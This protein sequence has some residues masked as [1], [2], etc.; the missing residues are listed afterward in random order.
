MTGAL[1]LSTDERP[2]SFSDADDPKLA[3]RRLKLFEGL[4]EGEVSRIAALGRVVKVPQDRVL[5]R[6]EAGKG[7]YCFL[8]RGQVAFAEFEAGKVPEPPKNKKKRITPVMQVCE[9]VVA[10]FDVGDVFKNDHVASARGEDGVKRDMALFSCIHVIMLELPQA[11]LDKVLKDLP[12]VRDRVDAQAEA[13]FYKQTLLKVDGRSE[14]L[15]FYVKQGF[16]YADAIKVI[17][18]DKCI[19]CDECVMACEDRHGIARIE[20]FGPRVG[21]MQFTLNCRSCEDARCIDVCNFDA[22]G[23]DDRVP[24]PE[25]VVYDNCVGCTKCAKACPHE[26]IRM[27][28]IQEP[29][30]VDLVGMVEA[31]R[32]RPVTRVAKG[33]EKSKAKKKKKPKR[34]ANKCDHCFGFSDMAC[35]SACPTGAIIQIDPRSLFRRDGGVIDRAHR[36]FE[37]SPFELGWSQTTQT[38]GVRLMHG[39]FVL[40]AMVVVVAFWEYIARRIAPASTPWRMTVGLFMGAEVATGLELLLTPVQGFLR[41]LGYIGAGMMIISALYTIRLHVPVIRRVGGARTWFDFHVVFGLAGPA[42]SLLHT[43]FS[44]LDF[45]SRPLVVTLWWSV[46]GI[47]V[48]GLLGRFFYTAI[49]RLEAAAERERT[50]LDRGIRSVA[51]EWSSM[52]MSAN[53]L[54]QFMKAQEKT[55]ATADAL[56]ELSP[57]AAFRELLQSE[58]RRL[59]SRWTLRQ[60]TLGGMK[61]EAL[62]ETT[63]RLV[64]QRA[65]VERRVALYSVAKRLLGWWRGIHIAVTLLMFVLLVAH[66]AIAVYATGWGF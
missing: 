29:E 36:Y 23:Y 9:R 4:T 46:F 41:W 15:D 55:G 14:L 20:R 45:A 10:L 47:V 63:L 51:D 27:V 57:L 7:N 18:T 11:A 65:G 44:V 53:V 26:A 60:R 17:Q 56:E 35:I 52:T 38:Q 49:P 3:L 2:P 37:R 42:L 31:Q 66:V 64:S 39:V 58:V 13:A 28:D 54:A 30:A 6:A 21:L 24:D 16:E 59:K 12:E 50:E 19:D 32:E 8:V 5:E 34:I 61:N 43:N 33:E 40:A 22:I 25:V 62:R 48:S 1:Q